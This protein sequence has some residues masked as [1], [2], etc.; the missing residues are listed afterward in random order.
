M[1]TV[2][3]DLEDRLDEIAQRLGRTKDQC[4]IEAIAEFVEEDEDYRIA[5]ERLKRDEPGIPLEEVKRR[6]GLDD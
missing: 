4:A 2:P 1:I 5:I 6:L 3:K